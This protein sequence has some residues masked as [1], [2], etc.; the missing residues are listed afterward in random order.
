VLEPHNVV[1]V[2]ATMDLDLRHE[3][4]LGTWLRERGLRDHLSRWNSLSF[5]VS[6]L[7]ALSE[8][9]LSKEFASKIFLDADISI[10]LDYLFFN[11]DLCI[12][13]LVLWRLCCLL[14]LLHVFL[15]CFCK[16]FAT[17]GW[18]FL[19]IRKQIIFKSN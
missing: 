5:K 7:V 9:S 12:I 17:I 1:L 10:E 19:I 3:L 6:E 4:L 2:Q 11:N 14:L 13:L 16:V 18:F 8:T 15:V